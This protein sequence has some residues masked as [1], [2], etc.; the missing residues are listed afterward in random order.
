[1]NRIFPGKSEIVFD[2]W[3]TVVTYLISLHAIIPDQNKPRF[4]K[5]LILL[6]SPKSKSNQKQKHYIQY[7]KQVFEYFAMPRSK[8]ITLKKGYGTTNI[9][10]AKQ[11][12]VLI[13]G[14]AGYGLIFTVRQVIK[15]D[16]DAVQHVNRSRMNARTPSSC[17][18]VHDSFES[19]LFRTMRY[20]VF[21]TWNIP[22]LQGNQR[23][24][25]NSWF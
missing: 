10:F 4:E 8:F 3:A 19:W 17:V 13:G 5:Q 12:D 9:L 18:K 15:D 14:G 11:T 25:N 6:S 23:T 2:V 22:N 16:D 20:D 21:S 7:T 1:M 24:I